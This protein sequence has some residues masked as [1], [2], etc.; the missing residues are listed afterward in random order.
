MKDRRPRKLKKKL[1]RKF[2]N[3]QAVKTLHTALVTVGSAM[4]IAA[5]ASRPIPKFVGEAIVSP[6]TKSL[7][8][9]QLA[10]E[11]AQ[12]ISEIMNSGPK[13]WREA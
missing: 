3:V 9:A 13:N 6:V 4:Q 11:T 5:I 12:K 1:K 2:E 7:T 10:I 8:C